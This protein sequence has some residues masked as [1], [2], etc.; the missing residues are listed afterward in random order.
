[1]PPFLIPEHNYGKRYK[2]GTHENF[3]M[4]H[5]I[6]LDLTSGKGCIKF[7]GIKFQIKAEEAVSDFLGPSGFNRRLTEVVTLDTSFL[8]NFSALIEHISMIPEAKN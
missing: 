6:V 3:S 7:Y 8:D 4:E 5:A 2:S 1:M